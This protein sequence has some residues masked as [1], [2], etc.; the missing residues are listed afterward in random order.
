MPGRA[1]LFI[2]RLLVLGGSF[3]ILDASPLW[4]Q[5]RGVRSATAGS[6]PAVVETEA[7]GRVLERS[8]NLSR[9]QLDGLASQR[10]A[11]PG[12]AQKRRGLGAALGT[13]FS[14]ALNGDEPRAQAAKGMLEAEASAEAALGRTVLVVIG[15]EGD[16]DNVRESLA[17]VQRSATILFVDDSVS[18]ERYDN[19][20]LHGGLAGQVKGMATNL[21]VYFPS[22]GSSG[23]RKPNRVMSARVVSPALWT[24]VFAADGDVPPQLSNALDRQRLGPSRSAAGAPSPAARD[25]SVAEPGAVAEG[26]VLTPKIPGIRLLAEPAES[27]M[28]VAILAKSDQVV[29]IGGERNGYINVQGAAGSGWVNAKLFAR[30]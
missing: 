25:Q 4:A 27:A 19:A 15:S 30:P 14:G 26:E 28:V 3:L 1:H 18:D 24:A 13:A 21:W 23:Q 16:R 7:V 20:A 12:T 11:T 9:S 8:V 10:P 17:E 29:V 2:G 5:A 22:S 6:R